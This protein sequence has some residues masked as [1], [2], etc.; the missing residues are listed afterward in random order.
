M[1]ATVGTVEPLSLGTSAMRGQ[2][3]PSG[4]VTIP[5]LVAEGV[6]RNARHRNGM[7]SSTPRYQRAFWRITFSDVSGRSVSSTM[8]M[9]SIK[10]PRPPSA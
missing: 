4:P 10:M 9:A 1:S 5:D 2:G 7:S 8:G 3:V 6:A